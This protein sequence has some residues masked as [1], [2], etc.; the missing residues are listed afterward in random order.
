[1]NLIAMASARMADF[2]RWG[3]DAQGS[4]RPLGLMRIA[5][6]T[7]VF[8]RFANEVSLYQGDSLSFVLLGL[9][10][11]GLTSMMLVGFKAQAACTGVAITLMTMHFY[12][13]KVHG[14][15]GW[16]SHHIYILVVSVSLLAL[17]PCG[18]SFSW[19]RYR[20]LAQAQD[21]RDIPPEHGDLWPQRLI[22]LQLAALYFWAAVDKTNWSFLSGQRLE[23]AFIW[24][25]T[26]RALEPLISLG[27]ILAVLSILVVVVEYFLAFAIFVRRWQAFVLPLGLALHAAF[28]VLLPVN[29]YSATVMVL[30]LALLD[31]DAVHRFLDRMIQNH[32]QSHSPHRL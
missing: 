11:F 25:F 17:S 7:I 20:A 24:S 8:V 9:A 29:T 30:Y 18:R 12:M 16:S 19:D 5:I 28:Y 26:G 10:F 32:G 22:A 13:G 6:A 3:A 23:E 27:A 1:M 2:L 14:Y 4:T 31:P 15:P 21:A